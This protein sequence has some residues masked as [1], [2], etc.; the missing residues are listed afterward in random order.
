MG[1]YEELEARRESMNKDVW[2]LI[3]TTEEYAEAVKCL[4]AESFVEARGNIVD[5]ISGGVKTLQM[6]LTL[7]NMVFDMLEER[8]IK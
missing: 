2:K 6:M 3:K 1:K 8:E 7:H 5:F 4:S